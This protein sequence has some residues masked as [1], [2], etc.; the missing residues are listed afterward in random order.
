MIAVLTYS[1]RAECFD[2]LKPGWAK[3][4]GGV[5]TKGVVRQ[6]TLLRTLLRRVLETA[7]EKALRRL[8]RRCLV[9]GFPMG[10]R[11]LR[12]VLR[13]GSKKGI[14]RK[15]PKRQNYAFFESTTLFACALG[16]GNLDGQNCQS[17]VFSRQLSQAIPQFHV[18]R[19]LFESQRNERRVLV[20]EDQ[21][22]CLGGYM[23]ANEH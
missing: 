12:R 18:K 3:S 7:V 8:L 13:A 16:P 1:N 4:G 23:S 2:L 14:L 17:L 6:R 21:I 10:G 19:V 5:H 11:V 20:Y 9:A 22:L 15:A